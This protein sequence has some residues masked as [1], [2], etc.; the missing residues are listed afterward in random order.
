MATIPNKVKSRLI[1][2]VKKYQ[3][4]LASA[5]ARDVNESDT[6]TIVKD[7]LCDAFGFDKYTEI[8]S[9]YAIR[10][11]NVDLAIKID[12]S[13]QMLI[14]VK[15]IGLDLKDAHV[16]QA[17]DYAANQGTDWVILTN[18]IIWQVYKVSFAKPI[19]Q[20]LVLQINFLELNLKNENDVEN[21]YLITKEGV[22]KSA[23]GEYQVQRQV[24]SRFFIG[25][26]LV[27]DTVLDVIRRELRRLS[28]NVRIDSDQIKTV[29]LQEVIKREVTEGEKADEARKKISRA[30]NRTLRKS[31][32]DDGGDTPPAPDCPNNGPDA[33]PKADD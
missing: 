4:I 1:A 22:S 10:G 9:E 11:T 6:V 3:N 13:L 29:L 5:K 12:N 7:I 2:H 33:E 31:N 30:A 21:M 27:S 19:S 16:K 26:I 25:A 15:A 17:I 32:K 8:T 20:E 23:L 18:G 28:P 24:L 14:E